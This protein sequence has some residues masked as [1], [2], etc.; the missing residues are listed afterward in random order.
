MKNIQQ[1]SDYSADPGCNVLGGGIDVGDSSDLL[2]GATA[3]VT[4][5]VNHVP[6]EGYLSFASFYPVGG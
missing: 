2:A 4:A 1:R 6:L 5:G 3:P